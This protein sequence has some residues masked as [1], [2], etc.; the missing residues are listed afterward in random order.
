MMP[1][2][3]TVVAALPVRPTARDASAISVSV[4]P[5]PLLSARNR[6][7]TY[8][9]VTTTIS[10]HRISDTMPS[11]AWRVSSSWAGPEAANTASRSA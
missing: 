8:L 4:P 6:I 2:S 9:S 7:S 3:A 5:S 11:T 1:S 10:A